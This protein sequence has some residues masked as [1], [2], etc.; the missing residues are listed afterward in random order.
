MATV[1]QERLRR[2]DGFRVETPERLVGWV[3]ETWLDP[4]DEPAALAVRAPDGRRGFLR[5]EDVDAVL[6]DGETVVVR[7]EPSLLELEAPPP[8]Q[9]VERPLWQVIGLLYAGIIM[10]AALVMTLAFSV[11]QALA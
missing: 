1:T 5:V 4:A 2:C 3:E 7:E 10:L 9:W 11:G 8:R 6:E